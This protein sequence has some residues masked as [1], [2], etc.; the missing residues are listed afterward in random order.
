MFEALNIIF[1]DLVFALTI[2]ELN[3]KDMVDICTFI[4]L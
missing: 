1:L 3:L 2:S 4:L